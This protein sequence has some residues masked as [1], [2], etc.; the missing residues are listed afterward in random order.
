MP[1]ITDCRIT[2]VVPYCSAFSPIELFP[3]KFD[4]EDLL[5]MG[6]Q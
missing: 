3:G 1:H 5:N 4:I 6:R 2:G